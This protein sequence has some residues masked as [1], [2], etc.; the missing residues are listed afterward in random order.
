MSRLSDITRV[1][2]P[3]DVVDDVQDH[4]RDA[5]RRENEGVAFWAGHRIG[6]DFEVLASLIPA[7]TAFQS[8]GGIG[9]QIDGDEL[10]RMNVWLHQNQM[11]LIAQIHSHPEE[12][13]HSETDD[14][15]AIMTT[16]G[17]LSI[18]VPNFGRDRFSLD[19]CAVYRLDAQRGWT[20]LSLAEAGQLIH[21]MET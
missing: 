10:F 16:I 2:I 3:L 9:V 15:Y 13:Y 20:G 21:V 18:V 11:Q 7:Q 4:L 1:R 17:G 19:R 6:T 12:A 5:G 14:D 8:A